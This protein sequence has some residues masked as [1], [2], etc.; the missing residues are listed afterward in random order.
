MGTR[1]T[2]RMKCEHCYR[3]EKENGFTPVYLAVPIFL[4]RD[5]EMFVVLP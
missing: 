5:D 1:S 2:L 3:S 4:P